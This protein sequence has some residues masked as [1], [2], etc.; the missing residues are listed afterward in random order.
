[1]PPS[2][3]MITI[4]TAAKNFEIVIK[5]LG[6]MYSGL[7][8]LKTIPMIR[9]KIRSQTILGICV[10]LKIRLPMNPRIIIAPRIITA[11]IISKI[12]QN[13]RAVRRI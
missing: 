5:I 11:D 3:K 10:L 4:A 2:N 9:P 13:N 7:R 12:S 1:M 8:T 6:S